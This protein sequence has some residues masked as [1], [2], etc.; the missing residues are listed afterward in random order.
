MA[1]IPDDAK[2]HIVQALACFDT[3]SEVAESVNVNFGLRVSRQQIE[4][5][6][7]T[8]LAGQRLARKWRELFEVTR[9]EWR[10]AMVMVP[11]ANRMFRLRVL[12]RLAEKAERMQNLDMVLQ[13][14]EQAAKEVGDAY[15]SRARGGSDE[16]APEPTKVE[17][18]VLPAR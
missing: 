13:V 2:T 3:P 8:K 14:M 1:T 11:I 6:D 16:P 12:G 4:A 10:K 17:R 18:R 9:T 7:P 15:V 5:Y